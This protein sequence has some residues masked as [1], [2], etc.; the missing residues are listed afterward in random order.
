MPKPK[1]ILEM[2]DKKDGIIYLCPFCKRYVVRS[3]G[4]QQCFVCGGMVDNDE[5]EKCKTGT[6]VKF[7]G[8]R[9]WR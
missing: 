4:L 3:R 6:K 7:D 8:S 9:P 2:E 1:K 5:I